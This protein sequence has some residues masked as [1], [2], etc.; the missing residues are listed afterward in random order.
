MDALTAAA[1]YAALNVVIATLLGIQV[2][3]T[4]AR[5]K[6]DILYGDQ[7]EAVIK[8]VRA[9]ANNA[10][11]VPLGLVV[12]LGLGLLGAAAWQVHA[13]GVA[14][15]LGRVAHAQGMYA[16]LSASPGR[17]VGQTLTWAANLFG[18]LALGIQALA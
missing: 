15:T 1:L 16:S 18:A 3:R 17:V 9:H 5:E 12:L 7:N 2:T 8:A 4:R 6:V 10:E 11:Y 13:L 14:L